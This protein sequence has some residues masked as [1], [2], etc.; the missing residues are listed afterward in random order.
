LKNSDLYNGRTV[1]ELI[2]K[3]ARRDLKN[4]DGQKPIDVAREIEDDSLRKELVSVLGP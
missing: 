4:C 2:Y 1:R 3:G